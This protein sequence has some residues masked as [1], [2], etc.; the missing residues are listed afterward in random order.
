MHITLP[1][2]VLN[3]LAS[4][5][6]MSYVCR[7]TLEP[8]EPSCHRKTF[9]QTSFKE[10]ALSQLHCSQAPPSLTSPCS[11]LR[12]TSPYV[13]TPHVQTST[14]PFLVILSDL[15]LDLQGEKMQKG[16]RAL[17]RKSQG[18]CSSCLSCVKAQKP[19]AW[20]SKAEAPRSGRGSS[21]NSSSRRHREHSTHHVSV[22]PLSQGEMPSWCSASAK[23][24]WGMWPSLA[25]A[26][27]ACK[28]AMA[29]PPFCMW[30]RSLWGAR[31][32]STAWECAAPPLHGLLH[33][34]RPTTPA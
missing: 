27:A 4:S 32:L 25:A 29:A 11:K 30:I 28:D 16:S 34:L 23:S 7:S 33:L 1:W 14:T 10:P 18:A 8:S 20:T 12:V 3:S 2:P 17:G 24:S 31:L 26:V 19:H 9:T 5:A 13:H 21:C 22:S 15:P 6:V